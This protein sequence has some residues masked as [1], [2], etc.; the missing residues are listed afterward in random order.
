MPGPGVDAGP[1]QGRLVELPVPAPEGGRVGRQGP[2]DRVRLQVLLPGP[3]KYALKKSRFKNLPLISEAPI[4]G[5]RYA[6]RSLGPAGAA[7]GA[8]RAEP[9]GPRPPETLL[10]CA[11]TTGALP[12]GQG[13]PK[14]PPFGRSFPP[15]PAGTGNGAAGGR[16]GSGDPETVSTY[17]V[18]LRSS[19][20][21]QYLQ[22]ISAAP[23]WRPA[24]P[25]RRRCGRTAPA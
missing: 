14:G 10:A 25:R 11:P 23:S 2:E 17:G 7:V 9:V 1:D 20:A 19:T 4:S 5:P 8:A 12:R 6:V 16:C 22:T 18:S 15:F 24:G 3:L 13:I 21:P